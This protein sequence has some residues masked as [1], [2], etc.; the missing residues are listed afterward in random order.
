MSSSSWNRCSQPNLGWWGLSL[1]AEIFDGPGTPWRKPPSREWRYVE[2]SSFMRVLNLLMV[3]HF[4][5]FW[6]FPIFI[7]VSCTL[8]QNFSLTAFLYIFCRIYKLLTLVQIPS[9]LNEAKWRKPGRTVK[10]MILLQTYRKVELV[11]ASESHRGS[12]DN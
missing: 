9:Y 7:L 11:A 6:T 3:S 4:F 12:K 5:I 10:S 8:L 1:V 2:V